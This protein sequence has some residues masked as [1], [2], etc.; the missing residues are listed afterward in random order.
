MIKRKPIASKLRAMKVG[1]VVK[2]PIAQRGSILAAQG[3]DLIIQ[4]ASGMKWSIRTSFKE[5]VVRVTRV[6]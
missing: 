5:G 2:Y 6:K 1:D 3:R 4:R